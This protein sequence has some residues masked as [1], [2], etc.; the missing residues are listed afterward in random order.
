MMLLLTSSIRNADAVGRP[1]INV[2]TVSN[3]AAFSA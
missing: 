1:E 2:G 3:I